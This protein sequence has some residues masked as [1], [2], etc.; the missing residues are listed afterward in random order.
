MAYKQQYIPGNFRPEVIEDTNTPKPL[1]TKYGEPIYGLSGKNDIR[2][3]I[4][5]VGMTPVVTTN[6]R[7]QQS[8]TF[9][10]DPAYQKS[11]QMLNFEKRIASGEVQS[12]GLYGPALD[13][14]RERKAFVNRESAYT[15]YDP[16]TNIVTF[17]DP[18]GNI[19]QQG[20]RTSGNVFGG[21]FLGN[22][23]N[24]LSS[25]LNKIASDPVLQRTV[26]ATAFAVVAPYAA[27]SLAQYLSGLGAYAGITAQAITSIT[28][29][30]AQGVPIEKA[31]ENALVNIAV[32]GATGAVQQQIGKVISSPGV[33]NAITSTVSSGLATA[34]RGGS[35]ADVEKA[36]T[37][38][39]VS[40]AASTAYK[41]AVDSTSTIASKAVGGAAGGA[42]TGGTEGAVIGGLSSAAGA[43]SSELAPTPKPADTAAL[44]AEQVAATPSGELTAEDLTKLAEESAKLIGPA[45]PPTAS[46]DTSVV[47][48][49]GTGPS[50]Q[51][52]GIPYLAENAPENIKN[53]VPPGYRLLSAEESL[54]KN[55][56][57]TLLPN[58]EY[59]FI[60]QD[61]SPEY[62][63]TQELPTETIPSTGQVA[64]IDLTVPEVVPTTPEASAIGIGDP[65]SDVAPEIAVTAPSATEPVTVI[66]VDPSTE[67][68]LVI[69]STGDIFT[70]TVDPSTT[71]GSTVTV[72]APT[73]E[74]APQPAPE[75]P[76]EPAP[77]PAPEFAPA[78]IQ[79]EPITTPFVAPTTDQ[80]I[81]D[82]I[83]PPV[84]VVEPVVTQPLEVVPQPAPIT[85]PEPVPAPTPEPV[86]A[87][88]PSP[89]QAILDLIN[90]PV[91]APEPAPQPVSE[92]APEPLPA[93][94][95]AP[96]PVTEPVVEP[97]P[98]VPPV[99]TPTPTPEPTPAPNLDQAI[100]DLINPP[101]IEPAPEPA[102]LPAPTPEPTPT[103][104]PAPAPAPSP[105]QPILDL[106]SPPAP[107]FV[108]TP[109]P[110][111]VPAPEFVPETTPVSSPALEPAPEI[112]P[113]PAPE[114]APSPAPTPVP[115]IAPEVAPA[116]T[117][118]PEPVPAPELAPE[119][120]TPPPSVVEPV[121]LAPPPISDRDR[122]IL[123]LISPEPVEPEPITETPLVPEELGA[124]AP[125][126][127]AEVDTSIPRVEV[128]GVGD[129]PTEPTPAPEAI[130]VP[131]VEVT[132]PEDTDTTL[133]DAPPISDTDRQ[134]LD[135]ISEKPTEDQS[136]AETER[137]A[138]KE[139]ELAGAE[140][141]AYLPDSGKDTKTTTT[142]KP[143]IFTKTYLSPKAKTAASTSVLGSALGT[144]GLTS[145]RGAGEIE[146]A[147]TGK[148]RKKVW[149]E[150]SLKLKDAL[151][152]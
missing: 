55:V 17:Y 120:I 82:L 53:L 93:P 121:P 124:V 5:K 39:L 47:S 32:S 51:V 50:V 133:I 105:D 27:A 131:V 78:P 95:P 52:S 132:V 102:P 26:T 73:P 37:A 146:G 74:P 115:E 4:G 123:D 14:G 113:L 62:L 56:K 30:V 66:R 125:E 58:G 70:V 42:V 91:P 118:A 100:L 44:P 68:A 84:S 143:D 34:A 49:A 81:L 111:P 117:P 86:P 12:T 147:G 10:D 90:P 45:E 142:T 2:T 11:Q 15:S 65:V 22:T 67:T 141:G 64:G 135:L 137:L 126:L 24:S 140:K 46:L 98:P 110:V 85:E 60:G 119:L 150:E 138:R 25:G 8:V 87:P 72:P 106:I 101:V 107:E 96:V 136:D 59:A 33:T 13:G 23:L 80:K 18:D 1:P 144:T 36:M 151:G 71:A 69:N 127:P 97:V 83:S 75:P 31:T 79:A 134:I 28:I 41:D 76:P 148:P 9:V 94:A 43:L 122:E 114:V 149:N 35:Q 40:S 104:E 7:D 145:S 152:V 57:A 6:S 16:A 128:S 21:G 77:E 89:D 88:A 139:A 109:R 92:P 29:Q 20:Q 99:P 3:L 63:A 116:P 48:D 112:A 54:P 61:T 19:T 108:P 130:D 38:G 103:P 129:V